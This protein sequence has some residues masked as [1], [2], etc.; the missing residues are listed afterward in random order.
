MPEEDSL[1]T[2]NFRSFSY[3]FRRNTTH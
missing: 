1:T 2:L 3:G